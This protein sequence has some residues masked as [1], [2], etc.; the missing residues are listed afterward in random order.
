MVPEGVVKKIGATAFYGMGLHL[1]LPASKAKK[2]VE[3]SGAASLFGTI[4]VSATLGLYEED[5]AHFVTLDATVRSET[6]NLR[7]LPATIGADT[8]VDKGL[9]DL[10]PDIG[11]GLEHVALD[12]KKQDFSI[13]GRITIGD[14]GAAAGIAVKGKDQDSGALLHLK[15]EGDKETPPSFTAFFGAVTGIDPDS[16]NILNLNLPAH[17]GGPGTGY[18]HPQ[19][20]RRGPG[21][22]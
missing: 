18:R 7:E 9:T 6:L 14:S 13:N 16:I 5:K 20:F 11:L 1:D 10:L 2:S 8:L 4:Y 21:R 22:G 15:F 19:P 17:Q 3:I 12:Q